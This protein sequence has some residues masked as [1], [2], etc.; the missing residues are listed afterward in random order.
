[1]RALLGIENTERFSFTCNELY[2]AT[3][4]KQRL[5]QGNNTQTNISW[6]IKWVEQ[7]GN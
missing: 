3:M 4:C 6:N 1:M 2:K 7:G 5:V